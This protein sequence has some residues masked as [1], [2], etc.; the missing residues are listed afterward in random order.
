MNSNLY[1]NK[2]TADNDDEQTELLPKQVDSDPEE[3]SFDP[4]GKSA[5]ASDFSAGRRIT[6]QRKKP[7]VEP[8]GMSNL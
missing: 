7:T 6:Y 2:V 1:T 3:S 5:S 4:T 8:I